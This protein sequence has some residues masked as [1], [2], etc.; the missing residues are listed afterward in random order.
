VRGKFGVQVG[1]F[2]IKRNLIEGRIATKERG[3][4]D[5]TIGEAKRR[6]KSAEISGI[7]GEEGRDG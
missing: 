1:G 2:E 4:N 7:V 3:E 5:G 6:V